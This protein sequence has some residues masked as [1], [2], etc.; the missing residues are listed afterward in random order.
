MINRKRF[1]S[2]GA[3]FGLCL[4]VATA[5]ADNYSDTVT[6]FKNAGK[7]ASFFK[8]SYAYA[9]FPSIGEGGFVVGGAHGDGRVYVHGHLRGNTMMSQVSVGF[10]AGGKAFS[11]VI[12]FKDKRA[13]AEFESG[14][15]QFGADA[16]VVAI[17][18]GAS[19]GAGTTGTAAGASGGEN[20]AATVGAYQKGMVV[21]TVAKGGA[22]F[23]VSVDG[24]KFS[25]NAR[26]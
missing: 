11:Q 24:Q 20:D 16:S 5:H 8:N 10:L 13:L 23:D 1:L 6:V 26:S 3:A 19:A 4:S 21:F 7:S 9:V 22:M 15:F 12:F 25:Y 18:A 17:T 14:H 2:L